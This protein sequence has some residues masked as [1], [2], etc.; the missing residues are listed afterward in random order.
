MA[1]LD[2]SRRCVNQKGPLEHIGPGRLHRILL[3]DDDVFQLKK[4]RDIGI[5]GF[6]APKEGGL[7]EEDLDLLIKSVCCPR[8]TSPPTSSPPTSSDPLKRRKKLKG[9]RPPEL[10][11]LDHSD[12]S[13]KEHLETVSATQFLAKNEQAERVA[14]DEQERR[15]NGDDERLARQAGARESEEA[16]EQLANDL[17]ALKVSMQ[18]PV[19]IPSAAEA[20][21]GTNVEASRHFAKPASMDQRMSPRS[22]VHQKQ[23]LCF[24]VLLPFLASCGL[25]LLKLCQGTG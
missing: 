3:V 14:K 11:S 10:H 15:I 13:P 19:S 1:R 20:S 22:I 12:S 21:F 24:P 18:A 7:R 4:A 25:V 6:A 17:T 8:C 16:T 9:K 2:S 5:Q 23:F